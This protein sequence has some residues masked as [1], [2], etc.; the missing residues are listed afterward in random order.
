MPNPRAVLF[1]LDGTLA[2]STPSIAEAIAALLR[3]RGYSYTPAEIEPR[4]GPPLNDMLRDFLGV[5]QDEA[6][7]LYDGYLDYYRDYA[8]RMPPMP[9]AEDL[10][11]ALAERDISVA[12]VTNKVEASAATLLRVLGW[13]DRFGAVIGADTTPMAKPAPEPALEA[14]RRLGA[15][16]P[17]AAFV[18]DT[19]IDMECGRN[20][21]IPLVIALAG[22][23]S[24]DVLRAAGATHVCASLDQVRALLVDGPRDSGETR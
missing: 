11:E 14:L 4:I 16:P 1:D 21:G 5:S 24:V 15:E 9:G 17:A 19:E 13:T 3:D 22:H 12:I 7:A 10:L 18:G 8:D 23:R 6:D 2:D 20:T